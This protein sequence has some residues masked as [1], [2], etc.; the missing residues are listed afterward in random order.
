MK[1]LL[2]NLGVIFMLVAVV[3]LF[4]YAT[5]GMVTNSYLV[6]SGLLLLAGVAVYV[7]MQR[8]ME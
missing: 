1:Y 7:I 6:I 2:R 8:V 3:L 4:I 5:Q